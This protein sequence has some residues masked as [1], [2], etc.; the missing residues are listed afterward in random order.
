MTTL[1]Y[2]YHSK[3]STRLVLSPE[4]GLAMP[5]GMTWVFSFIFL[6]AEIAFQA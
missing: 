5:T 4:S 2:S 6:L 3:Q 1:L